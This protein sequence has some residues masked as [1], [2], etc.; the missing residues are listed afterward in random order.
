MKSN[1]PEESKEVKSLT[2]EEYVK[3][4]LKTSVVKN[5]KPLSNSGFRGG[6]A[7]I[8]SIDGLTFLIAT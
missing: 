6:Y 5:T 8:C 4:Y 3:K 2:I 1:I 7:P